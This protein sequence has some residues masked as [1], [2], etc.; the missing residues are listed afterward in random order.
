MGGQFYNM[1]R[2]APSDDHHPITSA[3]IFFLLFILFQSVRFGSWP[4]T[5]SLNLA[6]VGTQGKQNGYHSIRK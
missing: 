6:M 3:A 5:A 1:E 2:A 4:G